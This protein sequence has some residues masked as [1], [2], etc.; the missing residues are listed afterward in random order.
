MVKKK[1]L[2]IDRESVRQRMEAGEQMDV[3]AVWKATATGTYKWAYST[4]HQWRKAG[5]IHVA[6]WHKRSDGGQPQ[7]TYA[8]WPG[9][10]A[11]RPA[12][13]TAQDKARRYMEALKA[14][15]ERYAHFCAR[16]SMRERKNPFMDPI[17]AAML[18]YKRCGKGWMKTQGSNNES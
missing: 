15:P 18:G 12:R 11:P 6:Q 14:D 5:L 8:W 4:L 17:H 10:D 2:D 7:P 1:V 3:V 13:F 9:E 16:R